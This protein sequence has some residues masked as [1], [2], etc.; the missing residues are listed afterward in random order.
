MNRLGDFFDALTTIVPTVVSTAGAGWSAYNQYEGQQNAQDSI[1]LQRQ[2]LNAQIAATQ[3]ALAAANKPTVVQQA[4][5]IAAGIPWWG[6]GLIALGGVGAGIG[7]VK[8][9]SGGKE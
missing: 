4:A 7:I 6:W 3:A 5:N 8:M 9:V 2:Q 1:D